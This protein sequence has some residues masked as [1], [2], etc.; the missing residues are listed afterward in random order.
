MGAK[1]EASF[2]NGTPTKQDT[3]YSC[4]PARMHA[5]ILACRLQ[6]AASSLTKSTSKEGG[7]AGSSKKAGQVS[8][9]PNSRTGF[10]AEQVVLLPKKKPPTRWKGGER[11]T[12]LG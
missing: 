12:M 11:D 5:Y 7:W 8:G 3:Y 9:V 6:P 10:P 2:H 1:I 4:M